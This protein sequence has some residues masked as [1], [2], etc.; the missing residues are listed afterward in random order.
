[1][2]KIKEI[3][4]EL[5]L[6][7]VETGVYLSLLDLGSGVTSAIA[8]N[9]GFNRITTYE[10][11]KRLSKKGLLKIRAKKDSSVKYFVPEEFE[12]IQAKLEE[13][14]KSIEAVLSSAKE[15]KSYFDAKFRIKEGKPEILFYEG[16]EGIQKVLEDTLKEKPE[17][18]LSFSSVE[19]LEEGYDQQFLK[20]Y[21]KKRVNLGIK[22]RGIMPDT[23][24]A[25]ADF[26][27][28]RN[29]KELRELLF[30]PTN[31]FSFSNEI[32][33][34]SDKIAISSHRRGS[35]HGIIIKST[36]IAESMRSVFETLWNLGRRRI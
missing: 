7:D 25:Q 21:W 32:D 17:E 24:K 6:N 26:D 18:I 27:Q 3:L 14:K 1:M 29:K 8:S 12:T 5:D 33:I 31:L 9:A 11:L 20:N 4:R 35:E 16:K 28:E 23:Q 22:T 10:A 19:S 15:L 30:L 36:S 2:S 34:Y 13:K